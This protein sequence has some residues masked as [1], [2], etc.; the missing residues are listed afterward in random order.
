[1]A[2]QCVAMAKGRDFNDETRLR[3]TAVKF[4]NRRKVL[5]GS[6]LIDT[7]SYH[8]IKGPEIQGG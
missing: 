6:R 7:E 2:E 4:L 3:V 1:M 5:E 8:P